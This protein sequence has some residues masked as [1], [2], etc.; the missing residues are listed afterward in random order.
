M[1]LR[2][3]ETGRERFAKLQHVLVDHVL[4]FSRPVYHHPQAL[5]YPIAGNDGAY[6][7]LTGRQCLRCLPRSDLFISNVGSASSARDAPYAVLSKAVSAWYS[8]CALARILHV[9]S[10]LTMA[11]QSCV[12]RQVVE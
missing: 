7:W 3:G 4:Q 2:K 5:P 1:E 6:P 8:L 9:D 10:M 11:E 12:V